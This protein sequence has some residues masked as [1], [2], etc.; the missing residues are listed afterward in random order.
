MTTAQSV[1]QWFVQNPFGAATMVY[2]A[3]VLGVLVYAY[4]EPRS[5]P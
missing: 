3:G 5:Q 4:F 1:I 2:V